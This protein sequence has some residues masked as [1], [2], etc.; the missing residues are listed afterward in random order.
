MPA[1]I[2]SPL[3][4]RGTI[5]HRLYD[6]SSVPRT[7][8]DL[9]SIQP[10]TERDKNANSLLSLLDTANAPRTDAITTLPNPADS[11]SAA[12]IATPVAD[13][14]QP[15]DQGSL[16]LFLHAA[17]KSDLETSLKSA[18]PAIH[19]QFAQIQTRADAEAY[20]Q[21]VVSRIS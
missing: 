2:V 1:V 21:K 4:P 15:A 7:L 5:D 12:A 13:L 6:H 17:L 20:I 19:A 8:Q 11:T 18:R 10:M 9:F 16:P 14:Q 3:I